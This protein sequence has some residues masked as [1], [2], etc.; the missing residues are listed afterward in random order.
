[1]I[2]V[3]FKLNINTDAAVGLANKMDKMHRS[4]LPVAVRETL[5]TAAFETKKLIPKVAEE[6]FIIRSKAFFRAFS[7]VQKAKGFNV[8]SFEAIVGMVDAK[9]GRSSEQAGRNMKQRQV[10][11]TIGGRTFIP[12]PTARS[13]KNPKKKVRRGMRLSDL[14]AGLNRALDTRRSKGGTRQQR[15]VKT[16]VYAVKKFGPKV[17]IKHRGQDGTTRLFLIE[18][19]GGGSLKT[20]EFALK[21]T[22]I[23][24]IEP[25]RTVNAGKVVPFTRIAAEEVQRKLERIFVK[26]AEFRIKKLARR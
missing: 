13:G 2:N 26:Q 8:N 24:T 23:Y 16:A 12:L 22:P 25:G 14:N 15:F 21:V 10:G 9:P 19:R 5:N 18:Q 17:L 1:M 11:G 4:V 6:H 7:R 3:A 20:E